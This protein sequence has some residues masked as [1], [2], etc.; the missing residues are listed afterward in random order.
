MKQP[1]I[2]LLFAFLL[3]NCGSKKQISQGSI[4]TKTESKGMFQQTSAF[5]VSTKY[6]DI[7]QLETVD[8]KPLPVQGENQWI[9]DFYASLRYP[10]ESRKNGIQGTVIL[11]LTIDLDGT[12]ENIGCLQQVASDI[13]KAAIIAFKKASI[14][15]F[16]PAI[17]E[18]RAVKCKATVPLHF[19]LG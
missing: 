17:F 16:T 3:I 2:Y 19:R 14:N 6:P 15:G 18:G 13:D 11:Q 8:K 7:F 1:I 10:P 9:R 12:V 4:K 5:M